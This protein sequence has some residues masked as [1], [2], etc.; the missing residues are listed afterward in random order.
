MVVIY[1]MDYAELS[2]IYPTHLPTCVEKGYPEIVEDGLDYWV[3]VSYEGDVIGYT[4]SKDMGDWIFVGNTYI[5]RNYRGNN[6]H[7]ILL[8]YRNHRLEPKPKVTIMN[9]IEGTS[10]SQ[11]VKAVEDLG[12]ECVSSPDDVADIMDERTYWNI[13]CPGTSI[14]RV[15]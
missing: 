15:D 14:W 5:M 9:P 12:Y 7:K 11:L 2:S 3:M 10:M 6:I 8:T 4:C 13:E 1:V